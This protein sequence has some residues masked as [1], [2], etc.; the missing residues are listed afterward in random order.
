GV[1]EAL[2]R[3][4]TRKYA[5]WPAAE[6]AQAIKRGLAE[7]PQVNIP[8][9]SGHCEV[10]Q[11]IAERLGLPEEIRKNLGQIYE[12]WDGRGLARGLSG[13]A[14]RF[15]VRVV[16]LAQEAIALN[17]VHGFQTMVAMVAKRAGG[18]YETELAD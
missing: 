7:A 17:D 12:R 16:T 3:A 8:I 5:G 18:A 10:A 2:V 15:P 13:D 6:V 9:L 14:V 4:M 11:R 1:A